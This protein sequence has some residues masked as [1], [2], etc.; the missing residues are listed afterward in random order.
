DLRDCIEVPLERFHRGG[1]DLLVVHSAGVKLSDQL[2]NG[3]GGGFPFTY[4][5][6][7]LVQDLVQRC[8]VALDQLLERAPSTVFWRNRVRLE[9]TAVGELVEVIA[10]F[11][12]Q[13]H[14]GW[15]DC[16]GFSRNDRERNHQQDRKSEAKIRATRIANAKLCD[17]S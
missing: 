17:P 16:R 10:R 7:A 12:P 2:P 15:I 13:V 5:S 6:N 8:V 9:P 14:V 11:C 4:L 3:A 1:I